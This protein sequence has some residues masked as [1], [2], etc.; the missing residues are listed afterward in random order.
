MKSLLGWMM[1]VSALALA[2]CDDAGS[3]ARGGALDEGVVSAD[4]GL[5]DGGGAGGGRMDA[6]PPA[7]PGACPTASFLDVAAGEGPGAG[8]PAPSLDVECVA[9]EVVVRT[10]GIPHF[11]FVQITPNDLEANPQTIRFP[12]RPRLARTPADL[13]LL[14]EA[15]VAVN[16][17][18]FFG[19]NEAERPDP[20]GDP[21]ANGIMD[22][23][24]GHTAARGVYHFHAL[25]VECLTFDAFG[26]NVPS[27]VVGYALDGFAIYGPLGC[28]DAACAQVVELESSWEQQSAGRL[29]CTRDAE[30]DGDEVCATVMIGA[31]RRD[32]C[33][34][35]TY[36]WDNNRYV[37]KADPRFLDRCNGHV[38]PN[39][40]YHYHATAT[41]PYIIGC[42]AGVASDAQAPAEPE[43]MPEP[44]EPEPVPPGDQPH[45]AACQGLQIGDACSFEGRDGQRIA[46]RCRDRM[47]QLTCAP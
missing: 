19:P 11:R 29:D 33:I 43:P 1:G 15:G 4:G 40:D 32:A 37:E 42:Y 18:P 46:G 13:P 31:Q 9:D 41:F 3:T 26:P 24:Q 8:Y 25:P 2:G 39:G 36:A 16:G 30:C 44:M 38:G 7:P 45:L 21:V 28:V 22:M 23:C 27:P 5:D 17:I 12:Q 14:G 47:G 20:Y 6:G 34:P 10:N 35:K